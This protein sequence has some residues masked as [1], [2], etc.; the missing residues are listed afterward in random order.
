MR[1]YRGVIVGL[2]VG[3]IMGFVGGPAWIILPWGAISVSLAYDSKKYKILSSAAFGFT[4]SFVFMLNGYAGK[5]SLMSRVPAFLLI[6][7]CGGL[8]GCAAGWLG[9]K[10]SKSPTSD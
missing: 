4:A 8:C 7:L 2:V 10:I 5:D 6:G 9:K 3:I 1:E